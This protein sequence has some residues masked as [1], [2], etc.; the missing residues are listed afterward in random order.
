MVRFVDRFYDGVIS[1]SIPGRN[2]LPNLTRSGGV[3]LLTWTLPF[4]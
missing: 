4:R 1:L 2:G 3:L